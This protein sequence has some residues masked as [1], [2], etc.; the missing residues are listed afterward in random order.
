MCTHESVKGISSDVIKKFEEIGL[1]IHKPN[2]G[3][4]KSV[5]GKINEGFF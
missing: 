5:L 2:G 4:G 1:K 3:S